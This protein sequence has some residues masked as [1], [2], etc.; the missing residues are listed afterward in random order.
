MRRNRFLRR[1]I[2]RLDRR[3]EVHVRDAVF[4]PSIYG[5]RERFHCHPTA[6]VYDS[7]INTM[8]GE[9]RIAEQAF[10]GHGVMLLTGTH[11]IH[12]FGRARQ[13]AVPP[14]GR[15]IVI[16]P[17]AWVASG[18]V[19]LGP[20]SVGRDAVIAAGAVVTGLVP[21]RAVVAGVPA[22]RLST[23]LGERTE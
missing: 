2:E 21:E 22:R 23:D 14:A 15:D 11:D 12:K 6:C 19:V 3:I 17:G 10:L 8:S 7:V 4:Q 5:P 9:V 18:A 13:E 20:C 16:G 1:L